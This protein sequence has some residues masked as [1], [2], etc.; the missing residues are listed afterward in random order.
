MLFFLAPSEAKKPAINYWIMKHSNYNF[1]NLLRNTLT[2]LVLSTFVGACSSKSNKAEKKDTR[3]E[4]AQEVNGNTLGLRDKDV[5]VQ[6]KV[7]LSEDLRK[8]EQEV[9]SLENEVYGNERYGTAGLYGVLKGCHKKLADP[10]IGGS[11]KLKPLPPA[12]RVTKKEEDLDYV[13][14]ETDSL[15][16]VSEEQ[17]RSRTKRFRNYRKILLERKGDLQTDIE[18]CD[19]SHRTAL[20]NIGLSPEDGDAQGEWV[21][22]GNGYKVWRQKKAESTN[23]EE[24]SKR[25][26]NREKVT[27]EN[28]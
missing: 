2:L 11:G 1:K 13:I 17:L 10:R 12:E 26:A 6:K 18:I 4:K 8:L 19:Q 23:P 9:A 15:V 28:E 24:L 22:G 7:M 16:G 5:V 3:L 25:K 21:V 20:I 27:E 14:D